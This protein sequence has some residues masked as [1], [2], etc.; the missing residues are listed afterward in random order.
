MPANK[1]IKAAV[2]S[3]LKKKGVKYNDWKEEAV[4]K[5][6]LEILSG[7]DK[8]WIEQTVEEESIKLVM[9]EVTADKSQDVKQSQTSNHQ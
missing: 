1:E 5:R 7:Q 8:E 4:N 6:K 3:I 9:Q 2:E